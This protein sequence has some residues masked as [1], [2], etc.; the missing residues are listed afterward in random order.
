MSKSQAL[1]ELN[2]P[3]QPQ[4]YKVPM[5][6]SNHKS[7][8]KVTQRWVPKDLLHAQGFYKVKASI[9]LPKQGQK[10]VHKPQAQ[11]QQIIQKQLVKPN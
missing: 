2:Q 9:W 10:Q 7:T 6:Q 4:I 8:A 3:K 1:P 5:K 11:A